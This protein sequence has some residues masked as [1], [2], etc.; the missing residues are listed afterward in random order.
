MLWP[1][2]IAVLL[3]LMPANL[4]FMPSYPSVFAMPTLL[5]IK[6]IRTINCFTITFNSSLSLT[7]PLGAYVRMYVH[8]GI[9]I[10]QGLSEKVLLRMCG[11]IAKGMQYLASNRFIHRDLAA[12]NCM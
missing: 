10:L 8:N 3:K 7:T 11:D 6:S 4:F 9:L 1:K 5:L 2:Y 12:R